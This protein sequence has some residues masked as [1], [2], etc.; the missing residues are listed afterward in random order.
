MMKLLRSWMVWVQL[1][2][3]LYHLAF[4]AVCIWLI[5]FVVSNA[6]PPCNPKPHE[7]AVC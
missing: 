5:Y 7:V 6:T 3:S 1:S 2:V 4:F